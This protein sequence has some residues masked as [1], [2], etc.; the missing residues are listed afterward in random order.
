LANRSVHL[1]QRT[2]IKKKWAY[3]KVSEV[4]S[5]LACGE[6]YLSWY[7]GSR[8]RLDSIGSD[9][10]IA[11]AD[12]EKKRL[13]L[14]F[15]AAGGEVKQSDNPAGSNGTRKRVSKA[16]EEYL[17]DCK[18]RQGKS[19][20]GLAARTHETYEDRLGF[21]IE[22]RSEACMDEVDTEFMKKFRRF[23]REHKKNLEDRYSYNIMQSVSTFLVRNGNNS[24]KPILKEMSFPPTEVIPYTESDMQKFFGACGEEEELL[25]KFFLQSLARDMEVANCEVRD[26]KF[27]KN[28]LH[29]CPKPDR[30]FRLKGKL[31]DKPRK[32]ARYR[33]LRSLWSA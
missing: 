27:D 11:L 4:L 25:F 1:Y 21:L 19:G 17:A 32:A 31:L 8:K 28:I 24:A 26:L 5:E 18:D 10:E 7:D 30:S 29:I 12:L 14:A 23:L 15:V 2:K 13:E 9:P 22:F 6:Y 33:Y 20:Y 16:V 3:H